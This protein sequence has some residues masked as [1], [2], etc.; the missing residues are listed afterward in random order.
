MSGNLL[1]IT[2]IRWFFK[3]PNN[4]WKVLLNDISD[5][6]PCLFLLIWPC[7]VLD[8]QR[9]NQPLYWSS[10][11]NFWLWR[12]DSH[13]VQ[14]I[15]FQQYVQGDILVTTLDLSVF[16]HIAK[17]TFLCSQLWIHQVLNFPHLWT[18]PPRTFSKWINHDK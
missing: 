11:L 10:Q 6:I 7:F 16:T 14:T 3:F 17:T 13:L 15:K 5:G 12:C 1:L 4:L 2:F 8:N 9:G 18:F